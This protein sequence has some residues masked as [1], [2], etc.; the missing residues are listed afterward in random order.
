MSVWRSNNRLRGK[1]S[2]PECLPAYGRDVDEPGI[3]AGIGDYTE[4]AVRSQPHEEDFAT[5]AE[6]AG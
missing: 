1:H 2:E 3:Y 4:A 6:R 5:T